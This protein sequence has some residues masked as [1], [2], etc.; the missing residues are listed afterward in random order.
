[1]VA[2]VQTPER[3]EFG[4]AVFA[5]ILSA[6]DKI[7]EVTTRQIDFR[8]GRPLDALGLSPRRGVTA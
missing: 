2:E 4:I 1:M 7:D 6:K 5:G 3:R 8:F